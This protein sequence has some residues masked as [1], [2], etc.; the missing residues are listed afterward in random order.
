MLLLRLSGALQLLV[1]SFFRLRL[2]DAFIPHWFSCQQLHQFG[3]GL[4]RII[5]HRSKALELFFPKMEGAA[6]KRNRF[7]FSTCRTKRIHHIPIF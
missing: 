7:S 3:V 4:G 6:I 2:F 1:S 5:Q